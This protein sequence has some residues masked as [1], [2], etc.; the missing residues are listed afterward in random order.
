MATVRPSTGHVETI[1]GYEYFRLPD[2]RLFRAKVSEP[3][4]DDGRRV[5]QFVTLGSGVEMA[6]RLARLAA[7]Q[8]EFGPEK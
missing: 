4:G 1:D 6:L 8:P 2:G 7:G 3:I 5:G